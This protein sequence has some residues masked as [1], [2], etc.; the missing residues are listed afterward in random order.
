LLKK[1]QS[2]IKN[3]V[4]GKNTIKACEGYVKIEPNDGASIQKALK[5]HTMYFFI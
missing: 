3:K 1:G 4:A 2:S 5:N